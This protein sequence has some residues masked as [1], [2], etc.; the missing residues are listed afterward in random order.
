MNTLKKVNLKNVT[1]VAVSSIRVD[2]TLHAMELSMRG[3]DYHSAILIS[4]EKPENLPPGTSFKKCSQI[5]SLDQYSQFIAYELFRY[6]DSD[7]ALVIQF[8]G[9]VLRPHQWDNAFLEYDYIGAPWLKSLYFTD[10]GTN[11]RVGN[12]GFSLRS[13]KLLSAL[14]ELQ[15]PFAKNGTGHY[16]EDGL[17]CIYYR[18]ALERNGIKFAPVE[19]ASR[20]SCEIRCS[21]S[22]EKPFGFHRSKPYTSRLILVKSFLRNIFRKLS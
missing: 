10:D 7:F 1:L 12:G 6:I 11:V 5:N 22:A 9:Y 13:K 14:N 3:I 16:N 2:E 18:K 19:V 17:I 21:D 8:D 15:L 4:H 20:F